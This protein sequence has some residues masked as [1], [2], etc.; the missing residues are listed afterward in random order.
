MSGS[1]VAG[2][3]EIKLLG[4]LRQIEQAR[5]QREQ[6]GRAS[7]VEK[8]AGIFVFLYPPFLIVASSMTVVAILGARFVNPLLPPLALI[9]GV[10]LASVSRPKVA[11]LLLVPLLIGGA[12]KVRKYR[13]EGV[14]GIS[15]RGLQQAAL[16]EKIAGVREEEV[17]SNRPDLLA[18]LWDR[19]GWYFYS[20]DQLGR[21]GYG[22]RLLADDAEG[23][24]YQLSPAWISEIPEGEE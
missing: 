19:P 17:W 12:E 23:S 8:V 7:D 13:E 1:D 6:R 21:A 22:V 20:P 9:V 18:L 10:G 14:G 4:A 5:A 15:A 24:L 11:A 3:G 2:E 16:L